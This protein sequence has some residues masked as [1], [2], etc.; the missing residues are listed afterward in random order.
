MVVLNISSVEIPALTASA[1]KAAPASFLVFHSL[2]LLCEPSFSVKA[3]MLDNLLITK[4]E[5][6]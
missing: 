1:K 5:H 4:K 6:R 3:L 2:F